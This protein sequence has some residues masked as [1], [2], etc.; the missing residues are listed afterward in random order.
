M[1]ERTRS[2][3]GQIDAL[4]VGM[5]CEGS[6][7]ETANGPYQVEGTYTDEMSLSRSTRASDAAEALALVD[8]VGARRA[9]V[10]AMGLERCL[11]SMFGVPDP[12][13]SYSLSQVDV[14]VEGCAQRGSRAE[15]LRGQLM[16]PPGDEPA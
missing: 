14:F 11:A 16:L 15:L 13:T 6:P 1:Y 2:Q 12:T 5:E 3:V 9:F 4:F 8:A 7:I 10:Y